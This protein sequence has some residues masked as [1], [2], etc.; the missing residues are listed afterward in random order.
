MS[1]PNGRGHD[2]RV[3]PDWTGS[4]QHFVAGIG[5]TLIVFALGTRRLPLS[6][7]QL[8]AAALGLTMGA[9]ALVELIEYPLMYAD[10]F[11]ATAYYDTIADIAN[12]LVGAALAAL[13]CIAV[14]SRRPSS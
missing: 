9:E 4:P 8:A 13:A 12:T 14:A 10:R 7:W 11:H 6:N 1:S 5:L 3:H 2:A